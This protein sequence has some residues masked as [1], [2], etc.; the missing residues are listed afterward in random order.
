ML[1]LLSAIAPMAA[2]APGTSQ[3]ARAMP[4]EDAAASPVVYA[5]QGLEI[6]WWVV[7]DRHAE[8]G[9][10]LEPYAS[11]ETPAP[12]HE[13]ARWER[14]GIR[15]VAV[16]LAELTAVRDDLPKIG[17]TNS[18]WIGESASWLDALGGPRLARPW[19]VVL[20]DSTVEL[21]AGQLRLMVRAW[22]VPRM[23]DRGAEAALH[24]ELMPQHRTRLESA[25]SLDEQFL[26]APDRYRTR[27][28][29]SLGL[30][31]DAGP[32]HALLVVPEQPGVEWGDRRG[33]ETT[34]ET[35]GAP[36][37]IGPVPTY[38]TFGSAMLT[39]SP[40]GLG[41]TVNKAIIVLIPRVPDRFE[42]TAR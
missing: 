1:A 19:T 16:P 35:D 26:P 40:S 21:P 34:P 4:A 31:L 11:I 25:E 32:D 38:P 27:M 7:S 2:C 23:T 28:F 36:A 30:A 8:L 41:E 6:R 14:S 24:V 15:L 9:R 3:P 12:D 42:L 17:A 22:L 20:D 29:E 33:D 13:L 5:D 10:V 18:Q 39:S 37:T